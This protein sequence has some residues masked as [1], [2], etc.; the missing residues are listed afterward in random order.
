MPLL[1]LLPVKPICISVASKSIFYFMVSM[2]IICGVLLWHGRLV[3]HASA[4]HGWMVWALTR[5]GADQRRQS[6]K[7]HI[8][9]I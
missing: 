3:D 9:I 8:K 2:K 6:F 1:G 4:T 5:C 7:K